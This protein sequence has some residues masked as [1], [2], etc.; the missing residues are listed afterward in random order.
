MPENYSPAGQ[1]EDDTFTIYSVNFTK[2]CIQNTQIPA[3]KNNE[4]KD[5]LRKYK[6]YD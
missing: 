6:K 2:P 1:P 3:P 5:K 4:T